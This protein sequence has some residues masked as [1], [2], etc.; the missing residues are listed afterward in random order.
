MDFRRRDT[1]KTILELGDLV[2][3]LVVRY[4]GSITAEHNDGIIRTPY[5]PKMYNEKIITLFAEIK[6][7]FDAKN[8]LNPGKKVPTTDRGG[9][10]DYIASHLVVEH[11]MKHTV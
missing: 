8:I 4:H 3:D 9:T 5:L 7:I 2:Y 11:N 10:K 1:A 6:G